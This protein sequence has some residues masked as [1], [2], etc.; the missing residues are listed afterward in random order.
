LVKGFRNRVFFEIAANIVILFGLQK[1]NIEKKFLIGVFEFVVL[2]HQR[3]ALYYGIASTPYI[4]CQN[5]INLL[6]SAT[7]KTLKPGQAIEST[8]TELK[9]HFGQATVG[10]GDNGYYITSA[11]AVL[12]LA[13]DAD[14]LRELSDDTIIVSR[15]DDSV[16]K[17]LG[18]TVTTPKQRYRVAEPAW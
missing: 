4:A 17:K 14:R 15:I 8:I 16:P 10:K 6:M 11:N 3:P 12:Y 9:A 18:K 13:F 5:Q 1:K 7:L 2:H